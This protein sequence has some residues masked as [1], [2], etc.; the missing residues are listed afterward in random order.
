MPAKV[1]YV[2]YVAAPYLIPSEIEINEIDTSQRPRWEA[3]TRASS[4]G[5]GRV[6]SQHVLYTSRSSGNASMIVSVV[7]SYECGRVGGAL[8]HS[9]EISFHVRHERQ[10]PQ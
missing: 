2:A 4:G 9:T 7:P 6:P 5:D 3:I 1:D 10:D 8:V